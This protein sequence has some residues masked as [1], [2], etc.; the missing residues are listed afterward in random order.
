MTEHI[1]YYYYNI[2]RYKQA[3]PVN[4]RV[5]RIAML[6]SAGHLTR[7]VRYSPQVHKCNITQKRKRDRD[8]GQPNDWMIGNIEGETV[9]ARANAWGM[10]TA[11]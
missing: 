11:T 10:T 5:A 7:S 8:R 3:V 6:F 1:I 9:P 4:K 2:D